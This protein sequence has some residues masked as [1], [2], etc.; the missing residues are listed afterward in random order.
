MN[1]ALTMCRLG[2]SLFGQE[3]F[4]EALVAFREAANCD[5]TNADAWCNLGAAHYKLHQP[6][7]AE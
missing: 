4:A 3:R 5:E 7:E 1:D 2:A 6:I